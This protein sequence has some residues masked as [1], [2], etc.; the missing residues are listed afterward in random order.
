MSST[1]NKYI[2]LKEY[3]SNIQKL[4]DYLVTIS[5]REKRT[6]QAYVLIEL[7]RQIHPSMKEGQDYTN[8]L[9]DDLYIMSRFRLD[10]D[11]PF[12]P[13]SP[14]A[15]GK[16]PNPVPYNTH[17]LQFRHYGRNLEVM[18]EKAISLTNE[19]ER[20]AFASYIAKM[21]KSFYTAWNKDNA[22]DSTVLEHL[23]IISKGGLNTE[24]DRIRNEGYL[25]IAPRDRYSSNAGGSSGHHHSHTHSRPNNNYRNNDRNDRSD[26]SE[27]GGQPNNFQR[28]NN[29][30]NNNRNNP[31]NHFNRNNRKK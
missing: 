5:D 9:W 30:N 12:P 22:D 19:Y 21:M 16:K 15:I 29:N 27:R 24:I 26:R 4:V 3:G 14:E 31:N 6:K 7:M 20:W 25:D 13:P 1:E 23:K 28:R 17:H 18:V 8:K 2:R 11:S 10:V